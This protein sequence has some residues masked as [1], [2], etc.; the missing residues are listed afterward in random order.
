MVELAWR[1]NG[2]KYSQ[3][4]SYNRQTGRQASGILR[5]VLRP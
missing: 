4:V 3:F 1:E 5:F 2:K